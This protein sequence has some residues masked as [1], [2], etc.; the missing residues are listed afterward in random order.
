MEILAHI[1]SGLRWI[2]LILMLA[3]I[4]MAFSGMNG[5]KPFNRKP[6]LFALI[7]VHTQLLIGIILYILMMNSLNWDF[8]AAKNDPVLRFFTMEHITGM[9]LAIALI[10]VGHSRAKRGD[11]DKKKWK[12]IAIFYT[13]GLVLMLGA[14]PW[15][16]MQ[17]FHSLGWF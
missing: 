7:S 11:T 17:K 10:T 12:S 13:I 1:H 2:V 6:A 5:G 9:L 3:A 16:F 4:F 15:P 8:S 14:I